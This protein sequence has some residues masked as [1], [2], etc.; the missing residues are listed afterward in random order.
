VKYPEESNSSLQGFSY[1]C[2]QYLKLLM[3]IK[4]VRHTRHFANS[5]TGEVRVG[6]LIQDLACD[7]TEQHS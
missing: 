7:T 2:K 5:W 1:E 3:F 4:Q 6:D